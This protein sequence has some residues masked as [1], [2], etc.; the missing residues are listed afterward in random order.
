MGITLPGNSDT[1]KYDYQTGT[2]DTLTFDIPTGTA[3]LGVYNFD[4]SDAGPTDV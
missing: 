2:G 1:T 3:I 4:A